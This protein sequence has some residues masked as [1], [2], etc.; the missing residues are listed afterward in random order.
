MGLS[1]PGRH[2]GLPVLR[3]NDQGLR[4]VK[5]PY[6][7]AQ[8]GTHTRAL[9]VRTVACALRASS[10]SGA[11]TA[12]ELCPFLDAYGAGLECF[13]AYVTVS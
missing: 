4:N 2:Y 9:E 10:P 7:L 13:F 11:P 5:S 3:R 1:R 6:H 8:T 12:L